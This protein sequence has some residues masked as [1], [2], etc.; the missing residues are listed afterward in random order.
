MKISA[1][2]LSHALHV[3]FLCTVALLAASANAAVA[4]TYLFNK[5]EIA[6]GQSPQSVVVGDFNKDGISDFAV[7]NNLDNTVSVYLGNKDG[8]F[9]APVHYD[10]GTAPVGIVTADFNGDGKLDLAVVNSSSNTVSIFLGTGTGTFHAKQDYPTGG[11]PVALL[12]A[13]F[14]GDK[15]PD[16]AIANNTSNTL[17]ILINTGNSFKAKVD[18]TTGSNPTSVASGHFNADGFLDLAVG[19]YGSSEVDIFLGSSSGTFKAGTTITNV[20]PVWSLVTGDFD[21]DGKTDLIA[22]TLYGTFLYLGNGDGTFTFNS[23]LAGPAGA[24]ALVAQDLNG[25]KKLDVITVDRDK[26]D[27]S[28]TF[29]VFI[30]T[31]TQV[32]SPT[33]AYPPL[34]YVAGYQPSGVALADFNRDSR[35]DAVVTGSGANNVDIMLGDGKGAFDPS[36]T[37]TDGGQ[38]YYMVAADF[39]NDKNID[40]AFS[41]YGGTVDVLLGNGN[42]TF[43]APKVYN[44]A[45]SGEGIVAA[46]FNGD[47]FID[48]AVVDRNANTVSVLLNNKAGGFKVTGPYATGN[49]PVALVAGNFTLKGHN[50]LATANFNDSSVSILPNDGTGKF[51]APITT[52]LTGGAS[53]NGIGTADFNHDGHPDLAVANANSTVS[54]LLNNNGKFSTHNDINVNASATWITSGSLRGNGVQDVV[55]VVSGVPGGAEVLLGNNDGTFANPVFYPTGSEPTGVAVGDLNADKL[56]DL[57]V[58]NGDNTVAFLPGNGDGTFGAYTRFVAPLPQAVVADDFNNDGFLDFITANEGGNYTIYLNTP[59]A[60]LSP[61]TLAFPATDIGAT[62]Q[63]KSATLYNSGIATLTPKENASGDFA[64]SANTCGATLL[65]G[66]NCSVSVTFKPTNINTRT[67]AITFTDNASP[68]PQKVN[69]IGTGTAVKLAPSSLRFGNQKVGTTSAAQKITVTNLSTVDSVTFSSIGLA[70]ADA[71]DFLISSNTC[72][73]PSK[74]LGPGKSCDVGVEFK[75]T[76][77][78]ARNAVLQFTDNGGGSPQSAALSGTGD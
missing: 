65:S 7:T 31:T 27:S 1:R 71:G 51:G 38:Q 41:G 4:E 24:Y 26:F 40:L 68:S 16:L 5:L 3:I 66:G 33:F 29:T 57:V 2:K 11:G 19:S 22:G 43:K 9:A 67:G 74:S 52:S 15:K 18:Y 61:A 6:T 37:P 56:L 21:G 48:L 23:S 59:A 14:N 60:A 49:G 13:D 44:V 70:G 35:L 25:D 28:T 36:V 58:T 34:S 54:I 63:P 69:L 10:T 20:D 53:P 64:I 42:G 72:P 62:S 39:N 76:K 78:G 75:P 12:A 77:T 45:S 46:D 55:A 8:T 17:S 47:G 30:N 50:D 32:G 73:P